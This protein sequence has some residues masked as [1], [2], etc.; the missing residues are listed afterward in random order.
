MKWEELLNMID[1]TT[2]GELLFSLDESEVTQMLTDYYV[3]GE[4]LSSVSNKYLDEFVSTKQ[5]RESFPKIVN[6]KPCQ[7]CGSKMVISLL[8]K[9]NLKELLEEELIFNCSKCGH[10]NNNIDCLCYYCKEMKREEI[11]EAYDIDEAIPIE[12]FNM[13]DRIIL[14]TI[15]QGLNIING[16]EEIISSKEYGV[17]RPEAPL[18][19]SKEYP[20]EEIIE[21]IGKRILLVSPKSNLEAFVPLSQNDN[22]P[23][24][25]YPSKTK[26]SLKNLK[27]NYQNNPD[28]FE[29]FKY[30]KLNKQIDEEVIKL[31]YE[32]AIM[33]LTKM[34]NKLFSEHHFSYATN[35]K[36][37]DKEEQ[38]V[39]DTLYNWLSNYSPSKVY[40][41][42]YQ[43]FKRAIYIKSKYG[44][45]TTHRENQV[46]FILAHM[47]SWVNQNAGAYISDYDYPYDI[48]ISIISKIFFDQ[49]LGTPNW[50]AEEIPDYIK[51]EQTTIEFSQKLNVYNNELDEFPNDLY[52]EELEYA[53]SFYISSFGLIMQY[54]YPIPEDAAESLL[55]N[56]KRQK[57]KLFTTPS[58]YYQ[59]IKLI[60][61][62]KIPSEVHFNIEDT[63]EDGSFIHFFDVPFYIEEAYNSQYIYKLTSVCIK[64][65][66]PYNLAKE[67]MEQVRSLEEILL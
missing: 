29:N 11:V 16:D 14:A 28:W 18:F 61:F 33:E 4:T 36:D 21:L 31:W 38:L 52:G 34:F 47:E 10:Q 25:Y 9:S 1:Y 63:F 64:N 7:H 27:L 15:L 30:P 23:N 58:I 3:G 46:N 39:K 37:R 6:D 40:C 19:M 65:Q 44:L 22:Y 50:F 53:E 55:A 41:V 35:K 60:D 57:Y 5:F 48:A 2:R 24:R 32:I 45:N 56:M 20:L 54:N 8:V 43:G 49:M 66:L 67:G 12:D 17:N 62:E 42:I 51:T 59:W 13:K 26:F